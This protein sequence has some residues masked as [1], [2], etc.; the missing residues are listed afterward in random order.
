LKPGIAKETAHAEMTAVARQLGAEQPR[1]NASTGV[2]VVGLR[3]H[4]VGDLGSAL[5]LL[6][7]AVA[8]VLLIACI[9]V[10]NL[11]LARSSARQREIAIRVASS[12]RSRL[13]IRFHSAARAR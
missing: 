1:T 5:W 6:V 12:S 8:L 3:E 7:G 13:S 4:L 2:A 11:L 9:N 10:A